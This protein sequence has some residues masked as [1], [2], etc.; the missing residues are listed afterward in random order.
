MIEIEIEVIKNRKHKVHPVRKVHQELMEP[1]VKMEPKVHKDHQE[2]MVTQ[3]LQGE[4][5]L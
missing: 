5:R 1:M 4:K 2:L 3:G